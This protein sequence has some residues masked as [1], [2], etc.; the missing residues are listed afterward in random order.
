MDAIFQQIDYKDLNSRQKENFNFQKVAG[1]LAD[2]GYNC[3]RLSDDWHGADFIACH[4][5]GN[6]FLKVQIKGRLTI[7]KKYCAKDIYIAFLHKTNWYLY[8][9]DKVMNL[10]IKQGYMTGTIS[11]DNDGSYSWPHISE[12]ILSILKPYIV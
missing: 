2:Y 6:R 9:H 10:L 5:D 1:H 12:H 3:L 11:W 8:P 7:Q 4:I